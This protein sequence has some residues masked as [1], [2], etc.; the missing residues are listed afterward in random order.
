[1]AT[2]TDTKASTKATQDFVPIKEIRNGVVV[3]KDGSLR[4]VLMASSINLALKSDDEQTA[5]I[6][7]FRNFLNA[8]DFSVQMFIQSRRLDIRPYIALLEQRYSEQLDELMK[9]QVREYI[10]FIKDFTE[11]NNIMTKSFFIVVPYDASV[12]QSNQ[13]IIGKFLG[14][15]KKELA[16]EANDAF[17]Q[18]RSQLEQRVSIIEQG[19]IRTGVRVARLG[20]EEAIEFFYKL[21]NPG[22]LEKP[23]QLAEQVGQA[24]GERR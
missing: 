18:N 1:M 4:I 7:Q 11:G 17:E 10:N 21:L 22:E 20:T 5:V 23:I 13:R 19:L 15:G 14:R 8:L 3:L 24:K 16:T 9:I 2:I 6:T 12:F